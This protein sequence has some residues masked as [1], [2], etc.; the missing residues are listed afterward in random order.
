MDGSA[1]PVS[2]VQQDEGKAAAGV[3][4]I[5]KKVFIFHGCVRENECYT[6]DIVYGILE[7]VCCS[8]RVSEV[9]VSGRFSFDDV[10]RT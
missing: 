2:E 8:S 5:K 6:I 3:S 1:N 10:M 7:F 4:Q 9:W